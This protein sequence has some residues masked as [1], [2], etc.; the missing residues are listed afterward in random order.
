MFYSGNY[1]GFAAFVKVRV[2]GVVASCNMTLGCTNLP[3]VVIVVVVV[4]LVVVVAVEVVVVVVV[5]WLWW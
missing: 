1:Q 3:G 2:A 5:L 4:V